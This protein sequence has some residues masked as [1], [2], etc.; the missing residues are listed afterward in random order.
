MNYLFNKS[1]VLIFQIIFSN[2]NAAEFNP[3]Q[4]HFSQKATITEWVHPSINSPAT[5]DYLQS[6]I[7]TEMPYPNSAEQYNTSYSIQNNPEDTRYFGKTFC[8]ISTPQLHFL[9]SIHEKVVQKADHPLKVIEFGAA[10]GAFGVKIGAALGKYDTL[11]INDLSSPEIKKALNRFENIKSNI[12]L[13]P[14]IHF[15]VGDGTYFLERNPELINSIDFIYVQNVEHFM[16]PEQHQLF[17][18]QML[19]LLAP[20]GK[21][22]CVAHTIPASCGV[23]GNLFFDCY[24]AQKKK[25]VIYPMFLQV[26]K[27]YWQIVTYKNIA[28]FLPETKITKAIAAAPNGQCFSKG[29]NTRITKKIT[30]NKNELDCTLIKCESLMNHFTP[31]IYKTA[32]EKAAND[33]NIKIQKTEGSFLDSTGTS[34]TDFDNT[35]DLVFTMAVIQ[36]IN[37]NVDV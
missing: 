22:F 6:I 3:E 33:S 26:T 31:T 24:V 28:A 35:K 12:P 36:K 21:I 8:I 25:S 34:Y 32:Y 29:Y 20:N 18:K 19:K 27:E 7:A 14:T 13:Q 4:Y 37:N 9:K 17:A 30:H 16:N 2:L 11:Y 5:I 15:D 1:R 23:K 10:G